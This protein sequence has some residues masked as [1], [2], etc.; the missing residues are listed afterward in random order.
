MH[1]PMAEKRSEPWAFWQPCEGEEGAAALRRLASELPTYF[2]DSTLVS[3]RCLRLSF[4]GAHRLMELTFVRDHGMGRIFVLDGP[5]GTLWLNGESAPIHDTNDAESLALTESTVADYVRFFFYFLRADRG[6]FVLIESS[7]EVEAAEDVG[8]HSE[9]QDEALTL[10]AARAKAN[11]LLIQGPDATGHWLADATV[12][13]D[14]GLFSASIAGAR[15]TDIGA[16]LVA[17]NIRHAAMTARQTNIG[18]A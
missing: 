12:A 16:A 8:N 1:A 3:S 10:E 4:Y 11:P 7:E 5:Q 18:E 9:D 14:G 17:N 13:Y 15:C 2:A 6:G